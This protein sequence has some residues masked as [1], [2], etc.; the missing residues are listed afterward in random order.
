M[1]K[2]SVARCA[3]VVLTLSTLA[4]SGADKTVTIKEAGFEITFPEAWKQ[5]DKERLFGSAVR[6]SYSNDVFV[7]VDAVNLK[8][9]TTLDSFVD[10]QTRELGE[11]TEVTATEKVKIG[12]SEA[13]K[14][15]F[16]IFVG[17]V[18]GHP[19]RLDYYL[20]SGKRGFVISI[21][22]GEAAT[23]PAKDIDAI[24][25]SFKLIEAK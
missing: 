10:N 22:S 1:R 7:S 20:V 3:F 4:V 13:R 14:V 6:F 17:T 19:T 9:G 21:R 18:A 2:V 5:L 8:V 11:L 24:V 12:E 15:L 16:Q 25:R 23:Y